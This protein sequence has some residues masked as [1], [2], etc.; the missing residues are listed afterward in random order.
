MRRILTFGMHAAHS[1]TPRAA[2]VASSSTRH[3]V[4]ARPMIVPEFQVDPLDV[5]A[6]QVGQEQKSLGEEGGGARSIFPCFPRRRRSFVPG[7]G[8]DDESPVSPPSFSFAGNREES[9]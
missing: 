5:A 8:G 3:S 6:G 9:P 4:A 1:S 2:S 7:D